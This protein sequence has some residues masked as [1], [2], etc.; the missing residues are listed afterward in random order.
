MKSMEVCSRP[1]SMKQ[2]FELD[3][4]VPGSP[5]AGLLIDHDTEVIRFVFDGWSGD[6]LVT[7]GNVFL[8]TESL[9]QKLSANGLTGFRPRPVEILRSEQMS[10]LQPDVVVPKFV[11]LRFDGLWNESD[12]VLTEDDVLVVSEE[13]LNVILTTHPSAMMYEPYFDFDD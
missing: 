6:Q 4:D 3:L 11:R 5:A 10:A 12:F 9:A 13:A 1:N 2:Y 7:G 8:A